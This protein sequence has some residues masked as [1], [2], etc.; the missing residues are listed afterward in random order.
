MFFLHTIFSSVLLIRYYCKTQPYKQ[1]A[2]SQR[3]F[4]LNRHFFII[5]IIGATQWDVG[6]GWFMVKGCVRYFLWNVYFSSSDSPLKTTKNV[7][8]FISKA[9][10][11]LEIFKFVYFRLPLFF[12]LSA[13]ALQADPRKILKFMMSSTV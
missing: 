2:Y 8:Y 3:K 1:F 13:I 6:M 5:W 7:F 12:S 10:F 4:Q 11:A 9:L